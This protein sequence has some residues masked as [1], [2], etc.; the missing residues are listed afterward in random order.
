MRT[1]TLST[2]GYFGGVAPALVALCGLAAAVGGAK[3]VAERDAAEIETD[4]AAEARHVAAQLSVGLSQAFDPLHRIALWWL[5]QGRPFS[6]DDW[7]DDDQLFLTSKLG[8]QR[9]IWLRPDGTAEWSAKPGSAPDP[10]PSRPD[11]LLKA[12][13]AAAR[14][15]D[16]TTIS[17]VFLSDGRLGVYVCTPVYR[18]GR[19]AGYIVGLF[20]ARPLV[21]SQ[22]EGR[23]PDRYVVSVI[24][25]GMQ[26]LAA[27]GSS[28]AIRAL[29]PVPVA[30]ATWTVSLAASGARVSPLARTVLTLGILISALLYCST[31]MARLARRRALEFAKKSDD[32]QTL[33]EVLPVGIAVA[34]DPECRHIWTNRALAE[35]LKLPPEQHSLDGYKMLRDGVEVPVAEL[36]MQ[37][38]AATRAAVADEYLDIVRRDGSTLHTLSYAAPLFDEHGKVRGVIDACVDITG[39]KDLESR[40]VQAEKLQSLALMAGG[41][42][43][44]FNNLL[45]VIMGNA[46]T[47]APEVPRGSR[48]ARAIEE[49][50]AAAARAAELVAKLLTYTGRFW[51]ET[52]P[53]ALAEEIARLIPRLREIVPPKISVHTKADPS[54]PLIEAG[55]SEVQQVVLNLAMNAV[56][57][58][59]DVENGEIEIA[60]ERRKFT[61]EALAA[62]F[63]DEL[64]PGEYVVLEV[65]DNG[66]GIAE[67]NQS[68]VFDPFFT[69]KFVG[70]GLGLSAVH[71][72]VRAHG[73]AI[74]LASSP[75]RGTVAQAIFPP[76][77]SHRR[78]PGRAKAA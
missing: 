50:E 65:R 72:I 67:E 19:F 14:D 45:T 26:I 15:L 28:T 38:A 55:S 20:D 66:C 69:T 2:F 10:T 47:A 58:L 49:V 1:K 5:M 36:P 46:S 25:N 33:L 37:K 3:W 74:R 32:F 60:A 56:E 13:Y 17:P 8:L 29:A 61:A 7:H 42:A 59:E 70:R 9:L 78:P 11:A 43:H 40:L 23:L 62:F 6:P 16:D 22:L 54:L 21:D 31:A 30:N 48:A 52:T 12:T 71:G 18:H 53:L 35:M 63:P 39:R 68:R 64:E 73:G 27:R 75:Q 24:A 57:A 76:Y 34:E 44:D 77:G 51:R 41:M 4:T